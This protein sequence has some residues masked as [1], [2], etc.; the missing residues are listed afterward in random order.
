[1]FVI[2]CVCKFEV[3]ANREGVVVVMLL[4]V[5]A[6]LGYDVIYTVTGFSEESF[7]VSVSGVG[8]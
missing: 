1:M 2:L 6:K 4:L 8:G 3:C 5:I 7:C